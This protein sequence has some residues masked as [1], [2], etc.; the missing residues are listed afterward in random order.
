MRPDE[1]AEHDRH[2]RGPLLL[3]AQVLGAS[4]LGGAIVFQH[5]R[6]TC[7]DQASPASRSTHAR[8]TLTDS[9]RTERTLVRLEGRVAYEGADRPGA[10]SFV[11]AGI[12]REY[13][14]RGADLTY[15]GLWIDAACVDAILGPEANRVA[16]LINGHDRFVR[17][18]LTE[19]QASIRSALR[20]SSLYVEHIAALVLLHLARRGRNAKPR[21]QEPGLDGRHVERVRDYVNA[22]LDAELSVHDLAALVNLPP[23]R[24]ARSFRAATGRPPYAY[25]LQQ[26]VACAERLLHTTELSLAEIAQAVGFSSQSHFTSTF[27]RLSGLTPNACRRTSSTQRDDERRWEAVGPGA[28]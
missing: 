20:P 9:G 28:V 24:F 26:R 6:W 17:A 7:R 27:R 21:R 15:T 14:Y 10:L 11:P 13:S 4:W 19:L 22:H 2:T 25:V 16:P 18:L 3:G 23:D 1:P 12:E 5:R 8:V